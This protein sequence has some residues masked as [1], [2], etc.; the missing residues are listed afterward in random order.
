MCARAN[1]QI[2]DRACPVALLTR[3]PAPHL[4]QVIST[5]I[6]TGSPLLSCF[7]GL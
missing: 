1:R 4:L 7:L 2:A 3:L 6:G 5:V